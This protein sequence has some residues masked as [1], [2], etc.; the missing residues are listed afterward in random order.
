M[1]ALHVVGKEF[2]KYWKYWDVHGNWV[3]CKTLEERMHPSNE[4]VEYRSLY[5]R[6]KMGMMAADRDLVLQ[7]TYKKVGDNR[8]QS[9]QKSIDDG[10]VY[11]LVDGVVRM[12]SYTSQEYE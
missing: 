1:D 10:S 4:F 11:P 9:F 6:F 7:T 5:M 12:Y 8:W 3:E 2:D